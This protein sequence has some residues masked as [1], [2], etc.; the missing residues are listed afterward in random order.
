M[1]SAS[2][3][4]GI[5]FVLLFL[6]CRHLTKNRGTLEALGIPVVSPAFPLLGSPPYVYHDTHFWKIYLDN[7]AK[8]GQTYGFYD[9]VSP[10]LV[11]IDPDLVKSITVKNADSFGEIMD[12]PVSVLQGES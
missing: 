1:D 9:G 8:L 11:T 4:L 2:I 7:H 3:I 6:I 12:L 10:V 5:V